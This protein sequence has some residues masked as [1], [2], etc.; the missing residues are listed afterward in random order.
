VNSLSL[1]DSFWHGRSVFLTGHTGFKGAWLSLILSR[2]GAKVHGFSLRPE[3]DLNLFDLLG[4][5][6]LIESSTFGDIRDFSSLMATYEKCGTPDVVFHLA[7][8]SL[9]LEGYKSPHETFATNALGTLNL[10]ETI[11]LTNDRATVIN[12]TTDKVYLNEER[13]L[14]F[15]ESD[16]IG[17]QDPYAA[18]KGCAELIS[19]AY[20]KSFFDEGLTEV[21]NVRAGNVIGGGDW[22]PQ[23]LIPD[24]FRAKATGSC[25]EVRSPNSI[26][27]WQHVFEP[28]FGYLKLV[29][30]RNL[31]SKSTISGAWN[32]GP[33]QTDCKTVQWVL[34]FL[35]TLNPT[36]NWRPSGQSGPYESALLRLSNDKIK[37]E[38]CWRPTWNIEVALIETSSWYQHFF[39]GQPMYAFSCEQIDKYKDAMRT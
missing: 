1:E 2:M 33:D 4:L 21:A 26:R 29:E 10:L 19:A 36:S 32:F 20:S 3:H 38:L 9:V 31:P 17:G 37:K 23:R 16:K 35:D 11:R 14:P 24:Y 39:N 18:S 8:Q 6:T 13:G 22:A 25:L 12:I 30:A 28:L 27:P 7:A 15:S 34:N 5:E